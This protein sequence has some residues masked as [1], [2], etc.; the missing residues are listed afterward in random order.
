MKI[1]I[2]IPCHNRYDIFEY[3]LPYLE[4][5]TEKDFEV[6]IIDDCSE[7][8]LFQDLCSYQKKSMLDIKLFRNDTNKGPGITR[9][10]GIEKAQGDYIMFIDSDDYIVENAI[11]SLSKCI[12]DTSPDCIYYDF[13]KINNGKNRVYHSY[14]KNVNK[15]SQTEAML[16]ANH[17]T[18]CK[19]VKR[20]IAQRN[21][22]SFGDFSMGED[23][24]YTKLSLAY[25][26]NIAYIREPLYC[27]LDNSDSIMNNQIRDKYYKESYLILKK[28]LEKTF[29]TV[30]A[31][32]YVH[33]MVYCRLINALDEGKKYSEIKKILYEIEADK[34]DWYELL[35]VK[36]KPLKQRVFLYMAKRHN[37]IGLMLLYKAKKYG[38]RSR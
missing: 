27:Y 20:I 14:H 23:Y 16:Y 15:I 18:W 7:N 9:N 13:V 11:S 35:I 30:F 4:R 38:R 32:I 33:L 2:I 8:Q 10:I 36:G 21:D 31:D 22:V 37:V 3:C 28:Q 6:I 17:S 34:R 25:C 26:V 29:P 24:V 19:V 12:S 1:S 5:Q